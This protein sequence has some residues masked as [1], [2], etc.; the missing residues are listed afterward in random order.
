MNKFAQKMNSC[1]PLQQAATLS[2]RKLD[3]SRAATQQSAQ[4]QEST[5]RVL[6]SSRRLNAELTTVPPKIPLPVEMKMSSPQRVGRKSMMESMFLNL[7]SAISA[8]KLNTS[9]QQ[10]SAGSH[11]STSTHFMPF[12]GMN[13]WKK[14]MKLILPSYR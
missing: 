6:R 14:S 11:H 8:F 10:I 9:I 4:P 7:Q 5:Q 2:D 12:A 13:A 3:G 1:L